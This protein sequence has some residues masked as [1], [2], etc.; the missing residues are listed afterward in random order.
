MSVPTASHTYPVV[1]KDGDLSLAAVEKGD[2][3][4]EKSAG[5]GVD[6]V[7][8]VNEQIHQQFTYKQQRSILKRIDLYVMPILILA[9]LNKNLDVNNI[10][11]IKIIDQGKP[12]NILNELN[13]TS[14]DYAWLSTIYTIPFIVFEIPSNL[15]FK[16]QG[17]K[18]LFF[19]ICALWSIAATLHAAA[20]NKAGLY[21]ARFFLGVF[22]AGLFPG[23]Y[24]AF[25]YWYRPDEQAL[26][27]AAVGLLGSFSGILSALIAYGIDHIER[28]SL[29]PWRIMFLVEGLSGFVICAL[30]WFFF[31]NYPED[32]PFL[33]PAERQLVI[34][35]LPPNANRKEHKSFDKKEIVATLKD[36]LLYAFTGIQM[37]SNLGTYGLQWWLPT[38]IA[39]FGLT[40]STASS[41]LLNI[42][43]AAV[44]IIVSLFFAWLSDRTFKFPRPMYLILSK[45]VCIGAFIGLTLVTSK[46]A[47]YALI[48]IAT[49][50]SSILSSVLFSWRA[51][52]YKGST[53]TA[54]TLAFQNG[55]SQLSGVISPQIFRSSFAPRYTV[56]YIISIVFIVISI[57]ST[58]WAWWLSADVERE[59]RRV[60]AIRFKEGKEHN[61]LTAV[62][63]DAEKLK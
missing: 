49:T 38:T 36:P 16:I 31:P 5:N 29:S 27:V 22:E 59:T 18:Q 62:D 32:A 44:G 23:I 2:S 20:Y 11:N 60:A 51:Q 39:S 33:T 28:A 7:S 6:R 56:P 21:A 13:M 43:P 30:I 61:A 3:S 14:D 42:P 10:S 50:G 58:F 34:S 54:F 53:S 26:R 47:L 55:L 41:Q 25:T 52:T 12:S 48:I 37:F 40:G 8:Q 17:P 35:R 63:I 19:R 4:S 46:P 1:P 15:L 24:T 9:Y 45:V 57:L